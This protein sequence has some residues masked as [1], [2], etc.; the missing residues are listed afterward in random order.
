MAAA[1]CCSLR[2]A[3]LLKFVSGL[4]ERYVFWYW[5]KVASNLILLHGDGFE[6][7]SSTVHVH[8]QKDN[9]PMTRRDFRPLN[10]KCTALIE[11]AEE[12]AVKLDW[13]D[14]MTLDLR[15]PVLLFVNPDPTF[16][17]MK[18]SCLVGR[19]MKIRVRPEENLRQAV[20]VFSEPCGYC[21]R[22]HLEQTLGLLSVF[23]LGT[24]PLLPPIGFVQQVLDALVFLFLLF[25]C[26]RPSVH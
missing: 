23:L 13:P 17:S 10:M 18:N 22:Q 6:K 16:H 21:V 2:L 14:K 5:L 19:R 3:P 20:L 26:N 9:L 15:Q 7:E 24:L 1:A 25:L 4:G 8:V 12:S 11:M